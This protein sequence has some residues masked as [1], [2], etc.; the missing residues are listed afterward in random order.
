MNDDILERDAQVSTV[1][2][3]TSDF[4]GNDSSDDSGLIQNI[5]CVNDLFFISSETATPFGD[6][7]FYDEPFRMR[8]SESESTMKTN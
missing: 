2:M 4:S 5:V 7:S 3:N 1:E 6:E 8:S